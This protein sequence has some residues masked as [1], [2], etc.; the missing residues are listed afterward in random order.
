MC[1]EKYKTIKKRSLLLVFMVALGMTCVSG[2]PQ[3][4]AQSSS[5]LESNNKG[6]KIKDSLFF[7]PNEIVAIFQAKKGYLKSKNTYGDGQ[8]I[9]AGPR[10]IELAGI[11]YVDRNDWVIWLN[12]ERITPNNIPEQIIE[13]KVHNDYINI[14]WHDPAYQRIVVFVLR[15]HQ[16]FHL[17]TGMILPG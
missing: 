13:L 10:Y 15:P 2:M 8:T 9:D 7:L 17:D 11:A 5:N 14:R 1:T 12:G 4:F 3:G 16:R 6:W